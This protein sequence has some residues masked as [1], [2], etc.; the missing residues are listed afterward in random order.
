MKVQVTLDQNLC[1]ACGTCASLMPDAFEYDESAGKYKTT[2][3]Y[4]K[5][6]ELDEE[7][8]KKLQEV[9]SMCPAMAITVKKVED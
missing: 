1:I 2:E 3:S 4:S 5:I 6:I 9:A 7:T 8:Y